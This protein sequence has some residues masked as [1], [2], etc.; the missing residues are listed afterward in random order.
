MARLYRM[1]L[2][3]DAGYAL[4]RWVGR[5]LGTDGTPDPGSHRRVRALALERLRTTDRDVVVHGHSHTAALEPTEHGTYLNPGYWFGARTFAR[6]DA[7]GPALLRWTGS[8]AEPVAAP[9]PGSP[10]E[11]ATAPTPRPPHAVASP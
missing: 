6:L 2:P 10:P 9:E 4:A 8:A 11:P 5:S 7:A 3:G 1:A